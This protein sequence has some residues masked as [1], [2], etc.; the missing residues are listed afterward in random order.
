[1]G[2]CSKR[3]E[4][5][6]GP[7][8]EGGVWVEIERMEK[9]LIVLCQSMREAQAMRCHARLVE[10][11]EHDGA[12]FRER[13]ASLPDYVHELIGTVTIP[14]DEGRSLITRW[15]EGLP[16]FGVSDGSAK[17]E[18]G[19]ATHAWKLCA[20]S[21]DPN[22]VWGA[23]PVDGVAPT[24]ARAEAQGQLS[25][26]IV[27]TLLAQGGGLHRSKVLSICDNI[28]VIRRLSENHR[29]ERVQ[30]HKS[31][32][33]DLYLL[34]KLWV[35]KG[36]V[37]CEHQWEKGHQDRRRKVEDLSVT[38]RINV[39]VDQLAGAVYERP[40]CSKP[41]LDI[42]VFPE[43]RYAVFTAEGKVV[44]AL[45][46]A[47]LWQCGVEE[48]RGY[49]VEKH[50]LGTGKY[51]SVEWE[52]L[53]SFLRRKQPGQR[54]LYVKYQ[55]GWLPTQAFFYRQKRVDSDLCLLCGEEAETLE[56]LYRCSCRS[57]NDCRYDELKRVVHYLRLAGTATEI[58][59]CWTAQ[60]SRMFGMHFVPYYVHKTS[61]HKLIEAAVARARKHQAIL[62][63]DG[64][65]QG[66]WST[67]WRKVQSLSERLCGR[68]CGASRQK[69]W[70]ARAMELVCEMVPTMW[71]TRNEVVHG[72]TLS[73]RAKKERERVLDKVRRIYSS[74]PVLLSRYAEVQSVSLDERLKKP[75]LV[76]Q[77][78]WLRQIAKQVQVSTL[79]RRRS[80]EKQK[81]IEPFLVRRR[82]P[83]EEASGCAVVFDRGK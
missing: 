54:S 33:T 40:D 31:S 17:Q 1:M 18:Q 83:V 63:W 48:L 25:V 4:L 45:R 56:H 19:L 12:S 32:D 39:E 38:A 2:A 51:E 81:S 44:S 68:Q 62:T 74:P 35:V 10:Q 46:P 43:E 36:G 82:G 26:L 11:E 64:F 47:I 49:Q 66:R 69:P 30:A 15:E 24:P 60:L 27:S 52:G 34:Y 53:H 75:T 16:V 21:N 23:G 3:G 61:Q 76:L 9:S 29:L 59:N 41:S 13:L 37:W 58:I 80:E 42:P 8:P 14:K 67:E 73:E 55:N 20:G 78:W 70:I 72:K 57:M 6:Q 71:R 28:A 5:I 22:A 7:R 65:L 50:L 79:A 77:L